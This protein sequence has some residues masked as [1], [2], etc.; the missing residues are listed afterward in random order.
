M[1]YWSDGVMEKIP[2]TPK[3]KTPRQSHLALTSR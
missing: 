3:R 1:E 2:N